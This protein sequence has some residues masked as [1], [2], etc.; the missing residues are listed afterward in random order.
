MFVVTTAPGQITEP[1]PISTSD[2]TR[3]VGWTM[4]GPGTAPRASAFSTKLLANAWDA[5]AHVVD[6][7]D[8]LQ[9][10]RATDVLGTDSFELGL[11]RPAVVKEA[12]ELEMGRLLEPVE[13]FSAESTSANDVSPACHDRSY[14]WAI[15]NLSRR[16]SGGPR[17]PRPRWRRCRSTR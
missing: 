7:V 11:V 3:A 2:P 8:R 16:G 5:Y 1:S 9:V 17:R 14:P 10:I 6:P 12:C 15:S 4:G 13:K